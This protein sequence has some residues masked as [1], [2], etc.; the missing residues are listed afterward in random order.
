[1]PAQTLLYKINGPLFFAAAERVFDELLAQGKSWAKGLASM[2][3][4]SAKL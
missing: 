4:M 1:M 2:R 3:W